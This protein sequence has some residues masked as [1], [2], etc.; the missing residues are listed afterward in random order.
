MSRKPRVDRYIMPTTGSQEQRIAEALYMLELDGVTPV[1]KQLARRALQQH[2]TY[3]DFFES[4]LETQTVWKEGLRI[5]AQDKQAKFDFH[6][7]IEDYDFSLPRKIDAAMIREL[8]SCRFIDEGEN[9]M[10]VG[11]TGVGKTH[12][13]IALGKKAIDYGKK[14]KFFKLNDFIEKMIKNTTNE[15][16]QQRNFLNSLVKIDLLIL[17]DMEYSQVSPEVS[18]ALYR[19][20]IERAEKG[21]STIFTANESFANWGLLFGSQIRAEKV[22]DRLHEHNHII[23]IDGDSQ[24]V[25]DKLAKIS[26]PMAKDGPPR[27]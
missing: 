23:I 16:D 24:R 3:L 17:D 22:G 26:N 25:K 13:A 20:I 4:L 15:L 14:V 6:R 8:A 12:L 11:P 5:P 7:T 9:I 27:N 10:F 1:F 21:R 19:V 18:N 2:V